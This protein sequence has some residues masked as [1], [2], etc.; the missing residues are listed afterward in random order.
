MSVLAHCEK[1]PAERES[2][3]SYVVVSI[4]PA[5]PQEAYRA[6]APES[7]RSGADAVVVQSDRPPAL[8]VAGRRGHRRHALAAPG[9]ARPSRCS[10]RDPPAAAG[11]AALPAR[12]LDR[13]L[14]VSRPLPGDLGCRPGA[15]PAPSHLL[16]LAQHPR[17]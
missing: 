8:A 11:A 1:R 6:H 7:A 15:L 14:S 2:E 9:R 17:L 10:G 13:L 3:V 12:P 5:P 4:S 16:P